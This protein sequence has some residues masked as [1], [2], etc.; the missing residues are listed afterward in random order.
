MQAGCHVLAPALSVVR[1]RH[2]GITDLAIE[3]HFQRWP[4]KFCPGVIRR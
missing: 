2:E 1:Q 3:D 4:G